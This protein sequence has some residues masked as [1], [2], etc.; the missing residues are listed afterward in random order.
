MLA[1]TFDE[2]KA[3]VSYLVK[4]LKSFYLNWN[5]DTVETHTVLQQIL[6]LSGYKLQAEIDALRKDGLI[7]DAS[8][9]DGNGGG[10]P[11][12]QPYQNFSNRP[13]R[14]ERNDRNNG[15]GNNYGGYGSNGNNRPNSNN[16]NRFN[17]DNNNKRR[18]P[19]L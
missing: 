19:N 3:F 17:K 10:R 11:A 12:R 5:K 9:R 18:R 4:L 13:D 2:R 1:E 16:K 15:N 14:R 6:E 8:P 7:E